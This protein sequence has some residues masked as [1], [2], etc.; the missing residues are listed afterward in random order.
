MKDTRLSETGLTGQALNIC[1]MWLGHG[2]HDAD[3]MRANTVKGASVDI[4]GLAARFL[5]SLGKVRVDAFGD[6]AQLFG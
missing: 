2:R 4:G 6:L 3:H 1:T 5:H